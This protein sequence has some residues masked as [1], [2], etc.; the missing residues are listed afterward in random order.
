MDEAI[1]YTRRLLFT[2]GSTH[3]IL[4]QRQIAAIWHNIAFTHACVGQGKSHARPRMLACTVL[5]LCMLT[6]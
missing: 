2:H 4:W 3:A 1:D 5:Q 6:T